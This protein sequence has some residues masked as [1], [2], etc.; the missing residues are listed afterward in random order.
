[1]A[2]IQI[3]GRDGFD[4][5]AALSSIKDDPD[6]TRFGRPTDVIPLRMEQLNADVEDALSA[7]S[8]PRSKVG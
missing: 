4:W 5:R 6:A 7:S 1:M 8:R 2:A 3:W